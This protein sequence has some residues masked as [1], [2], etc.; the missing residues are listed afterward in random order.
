MVEN[1]DF[2][3]VLYKMRQTKASY[4]IQARKRTKTNT[5]HAQM[6]TRTHNHSHAQKLEQ[7]L[8]YLMKQNFPYPE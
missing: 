2:P 4:G 5:Q 6:H 8:I 1:Q 3:Q 7:N